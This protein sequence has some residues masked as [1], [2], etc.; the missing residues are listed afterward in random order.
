MRLSVYS[1]PQY[2][3]KDMSQSKATTICSLIYENKYFSIKQNNTFK[4][5]CH[6]N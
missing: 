1:V 3:I 5:S 2:K 6:Q 4:K